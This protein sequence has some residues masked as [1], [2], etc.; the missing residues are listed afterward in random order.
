MD[1]LT[2]ACVKVATLQGHHSTETYALLQ[3]QL[4]PT[5]YYPGKA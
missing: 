4:T 5:S 2:D 3:L 1:E